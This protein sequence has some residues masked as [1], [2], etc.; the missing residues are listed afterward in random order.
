MI[1]DHC[2]CDDSNTEIRPCLRGFSGKRE[3]LCDECYEDL[4]QCEC[5]GDRP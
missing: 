5:E 1:C 2:H 3:Y 4:C